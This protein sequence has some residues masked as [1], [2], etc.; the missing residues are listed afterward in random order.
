[1]SLNFKRQGTEFLIY[2]ARQ[3]TAEKLSNSSCSCC[4]AETCSGFSISQSV[5]SW[6]LVARRAP[7][8]FISRR[9]SIWLSACVIETAFAFSPAL[10]VLMTHIYGYNW[11]RQN[12]FGSRFSAREERRGYRCRPLD[13]GVASSHCSGIQQWMMCVP[14][15]F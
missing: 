9:L 12:K 4:H 3:T 13:G 1:M 5:S 7:L 11:R 15:S 10:R 6:L 14:V 8:L 2:D